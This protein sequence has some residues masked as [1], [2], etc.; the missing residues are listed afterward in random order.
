MEILLSRKISHIILIILM[1]LGI[2]GSYF[3]II[4]NTKIFISFPCFQF[5]ISWLIFVVF[6]S[7]CKN[8]EFRSPIVTNHNVNN[9][10]HY[11]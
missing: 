2:G 10:F 4:E 7:D 11:M 3:D 9:H 5:F 1:M 6:I 8:D